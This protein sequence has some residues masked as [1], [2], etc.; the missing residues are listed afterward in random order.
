MCEYGGNCPHH[1]HGSCYNSSSRPHPLR[2]NSLLMEGVFAEEVHSR[3]LQLL[4][5]GV[6]LTVREHEAA[7]GGRGGVL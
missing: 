6:A 1:E 3:E 7:A 2:L 4:L 5:T